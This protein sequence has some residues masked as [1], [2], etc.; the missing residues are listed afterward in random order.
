MRKNLQLRA[1]LTQPDVGLARRV[2]HGGTDE[3]ALGGDERGRRVLALLARGLLHAGRDVHVAQHG[4]HDAWTRWARVDRGEELPL[5]GEPD[6]HGTSG[7]ERQDRAVAPR[8]I[9]QR[10]RAVVA[11]H[12]T[13]EVAR[14]APSRGGASAGTSPPSSNTWAAASGPRAATRARSSP[15]SMRTRSLS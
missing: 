13:R 5:A 6:R 2:D 15:F 9:P 4:R 1:D 3:H 11:H 7:R 8:R 12:G 14:F 10:E